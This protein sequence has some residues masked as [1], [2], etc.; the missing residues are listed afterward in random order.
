MW[1]KSIIRAHRVLR[2]EGGECGEGGE[3]HVG[4]G[5]GVRLSVCF[6][7]RFL[8]AACQVNGKGQPPAQGD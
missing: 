7:L 6:M 4:G 3:K 2:G 8:H 5:R 1:G